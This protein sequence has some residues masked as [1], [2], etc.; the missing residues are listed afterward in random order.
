M[1]VIKA[2]MSVCAQIN[3]DS[4]PRIVRSS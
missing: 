2:W 1:G 3:T 4:G